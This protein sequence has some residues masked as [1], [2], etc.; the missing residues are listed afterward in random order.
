LL[1]AWL[2]GDLRLVK[3]PHFKVLH[4]E[5][6]GG[7]ERRVVERAGREGMPLQHLVVYENPVFVPSAD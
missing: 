2:F 6:W 5:V 1:Q 7:R 4:L 3:A